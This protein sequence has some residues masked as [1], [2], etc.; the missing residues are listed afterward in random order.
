MP[1]MKIHSSFTRITCNSNSITDNQWS[2]QNSISSECNLRAINKLSKS[3]CCVQ[4]E[5]DH[6]WSA[7]VTPNRHTVGR[8]DLV[9]KGWAPSSSAVVGI[10]ALAYGYI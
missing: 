2:S 4:V 6:I 3:S 10:N 7:F 5:L 8:L 1:L 9:P